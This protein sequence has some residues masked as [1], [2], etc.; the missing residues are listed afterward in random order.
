MNIKIE[1]HSPASS[2]PSERGEWERTSHLGLSAPIGPY[3]SAVIDVVWFAGYK[4]LDIC[5]LYETMASRPLT[6]DETYTRLWSVWGTLPCLVLPSNL[7]L[8]QLALLTC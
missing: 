3:P 8:S 2:P 1:T 6:P 7:Y 4:L 5:C